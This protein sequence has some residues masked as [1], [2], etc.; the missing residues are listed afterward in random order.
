MRYKLVIFDLDGTLLDT[1]EDLAGALNMTLASRGIRTLGS[2]VI[3]GYVGNGAAKL[4]E[5]VLAGTGHENEAESVLSDYKRNYF[6]NCT[7]KTC[8]FDGIVRL[9]ED[10]HSAGLYVAVNTNKPQDTADKV[11]DHLIPG[12]VDLVA[13]K[14]GDVPCKPEPDGVFA[15]MSHFGVENKECL[16]VGDSEVDVATGHNAGVDVISVDWGFKSREFLMEHGAE[17]ICSSAEE[18]RQKI[19]G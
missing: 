11:I 14:R 4:V 18:L 15:C 2:D 1:G 13:G 10:L 9:L 12:L 6:D 16:Y 5:R 7:I 17:V 8:P 3:G 19:L